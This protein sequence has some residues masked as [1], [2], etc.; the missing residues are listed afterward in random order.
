VPLIDGGG[1]DLDNL[2]LL[3]TKCHKSKTAAENSERAARARVTDV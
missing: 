3:C 1:F 2:Q